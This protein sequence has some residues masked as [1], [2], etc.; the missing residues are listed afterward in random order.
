[1]DTILVSPP[2]QAKPEGSHTDV[3]DTLKMVQRNSQYIMGRDFPFYLLLAYR[4]HL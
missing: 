2:P 4:M 1:M 3:N